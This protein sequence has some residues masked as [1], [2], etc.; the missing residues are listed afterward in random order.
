MK[1]NSNFE[2]EKTLL[3][4]GF[5]NICGV[6]EAGRGP[7]AGPVTAGA[8]ILNINEEII[9]LDDSKKIKSEVKRKILYQDIITKAKDY[10]VASGSVSDIDELGILNATFKAMREAVE[11]LS[12]PPDYLLIDGNIYRGFDDYKGECVIGGD[13]KSL[14]ISAASILAKVT[15]DEY[16]NELHAIYPEYNFIKHKGYGTKSHCES[17]LEYGH[18]DEH[19]RMFLRKLYEKNNRD[20]Q[21]SRRTSL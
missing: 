5:I 12:I 13:A 11:S 17:I 18:C 14:S 2:I 4:K 16:M 21:S 1:I 6:D 15:R 20:W 3:Q 10:A 19:R 8:V 7:F 9:G